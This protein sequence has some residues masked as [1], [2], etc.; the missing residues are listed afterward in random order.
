MPSK[1]YLEHE[2]SL[3]DRFASAYDRSLAGYA[4]EVE[5]AS[6]WSVLRQ[7]FRAGGVMLDAGCGTGRFAQRLIERGARVVGVDHSFQMLRIAGTRPSDPLARIAQGDLRFLPFRDAA[8]PQILCS[9]VIMHLI[10]DEDAAGMLRELARVL[11]PGGQ[12]VISAY[13]YSLPRRFIG[14]KRRVNDPSQ[15]SYRRYT[16]DEFVALL[17]HAFAPEE[18]VGVRGMMNFVGKPFT[19]HRWLP[20]RAWPALIRADVRL[21]NTSLGYWSGWQLLAEVRKLR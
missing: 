17:R 13:N 4:E 16:K 11:R 18:I 6:L 3:M 8:F 14:D 7:G 19:L 2:R 20:R 9:G 12:L 10:D 15:P 21:K 5:W 1:S